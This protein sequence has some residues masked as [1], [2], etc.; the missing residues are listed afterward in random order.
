MSDDAERLAQLTGVIDS[1]LGGRESPAPRVWSL[2]A[3]E[4]GLLRD[5]IGTAHAWGAF[6]LVSTLLAVSLDSPSPR[7]ICSECRQPILGVVYRTCRRTTIG[8]HYPTYCAACARWWYWNTGSCQPRPCLGCGRAT[9]CGGFRSDALHVCSFACHDRALRD[10]LQARRL[11]SRQEHRRLGTGRRLITG[12]GP[13]LLP[14]VGKTVPIANGAGPRCICGTPFTDEQRRID[15]RYCS[16][17]CRQRAYRR[18]KATD[19]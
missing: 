14:A 8:A 13:L 15:V 6:E 1:A 12:G 7:C 19:A 17:A 4:T 2:V 3:F 5:P 9:V 10:R 16:D 11:A 18:R